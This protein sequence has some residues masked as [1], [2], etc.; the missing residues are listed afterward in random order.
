MKILKAS[1]TIGSSR[2]HH[3]ALSVFV[4]ALCLWLLIHVGAPQIAAAAEEKPTRTQGQL[5]V[6]VL[7]VDKLGIYV[8][9]MVFYWDSSLA[10]QK[11]SALTSAAER[12]RNKRATITYSAQGSPTQ[13]KRPMV[14]DIVPFQEQTSPMDHGTASGETS[15]TL[16]SSDEIASFSNRPA[17]TSSVKP[18]PER[19]S[20]STAGTAGTPP[21]PEEDESSGLEDSRQ[22]SQVSSTVIPIQKRDVLMLVEHL[23]HLTGKKSLD[24]ILYYYGDS[25]NYYAR[26]DVG[27]DYIRRDLGYYFK[28]WDT[29]R[30]GLEGDVQ[31]VDTPRPDV[32]VVRFQSSYTVENEKK[33]V[34]G[35]TDNTWKVQRT[36]TGLKV[37]DQ[38]QTVV[39]SHIAENP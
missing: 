8:P 4:N 15:E 26:G 1:F 29:I 9:D 36:H 37:I 16:R 18:F 13:D 6:T 39:S 17:E 20:S 27:K 28:N 25:V 21:A 14:L 11:L 3:P 7:H 30:C 33:S 22:A 24:S 35:K 31:L 23:L 5:N 10:K 38:K 12:L 2:R 32:K 34:S 19:D